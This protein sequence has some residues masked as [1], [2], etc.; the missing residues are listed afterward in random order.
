M[1][2]EVEVTEDGKG[3]W[4]ATAVE[5]GVSATGRSEPEALA[6][7]ME[8]LTAHLK[9]GGTRSGTPSSGASSTRS[10]RS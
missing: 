5:Y 3:G 10:S 4:T 1:Q 8:A 2:F 9:R 7:I 6:R